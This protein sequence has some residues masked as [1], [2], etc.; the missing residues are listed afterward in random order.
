MYYIRYGAI[1]IHCLTILY[2]IYTL[3]LDMGMV[4]SLVLPCLHCTFTIGG[5]SVITVQKTVGE[6]IYTN[7]YIHVQRDSTSNTP[8]VVCVLEKTRESCC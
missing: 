3:K 1:N 8:L 2:I 4:K 5:V 6:A 7:C